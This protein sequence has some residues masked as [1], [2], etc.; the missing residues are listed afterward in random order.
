[1]VFDSIW[2]TPPGYEEFAGELKQ[3]KLS[4]DL[5]RNG[6]PVIYLFVYISIGF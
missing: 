3:L 4:L 5:F 1:M 2:S 6:G